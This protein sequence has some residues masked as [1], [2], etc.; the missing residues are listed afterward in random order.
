MTLEDHVGD[1]L[2]KARGGMGV[3]A[4]EAAGVAGLSPADYA[5]LERAGACKRRPDFAALAGQLG[6]HPARLESLARGWQPQ[7]RDL[8]GWRELRALTTTE[9]MAVNCYLVWDEATREAALFDTGWDAGPVLELISVKGL[10]LNHLFVTHGH[11]DHVAALGAIQ[12]RFPKVRLHSGS[13]RAPVDQRNRPDEFVHLGNLRVTHRPTPGHAEDGVTYV[14]GNWPE[15][16]PHVAIVGDALFA[17]SMGRAPGAAFDIARRAIQERIFSLPPE[18]LI[19]PGHG[20]VT[21][22]GEER[23]NNPFF[24]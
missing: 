17:G 8:G 7:A 1:I 3:S 20:P 19:C 16:A 9:G 13:A 24:R 2:A 6:L 18:T 21:T 12:G 23:A 22:V 5:E 4:E 14:V 10:A 11:H 15:D